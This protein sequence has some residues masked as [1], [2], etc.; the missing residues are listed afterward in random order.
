MSVKKFIIIL[1]M[2]VFA[3]FLA[4]WLFASPIDRHMAGTLAGL[5][6]T[7]AAL[8]PLFLLQRPHWWIWSVNWLS[9]FF[10]MFIV[11]PIL[12]IQLLKPEEPFGEANL[13][14]LVTGAQ[15]HS[16]SQTT[17]MAMILALLIDFT[18]RQIG[19]KRASKAGDSDKALK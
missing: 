4:I 9:L 13:L 17:Y 3:V 19:L 18:R 6:F 15:L 8:L 14:G 7:G 11:V 16:W 10:L 1:V 12:L 2:Q 5:G